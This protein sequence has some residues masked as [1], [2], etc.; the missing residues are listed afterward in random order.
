MAPI[1]T[2][3]FLIGISSLGL[4]IFALWLQHFQDIQPCPM[5][6]IQRYIFILICFFALALTVHNPKK[7]GRIT[8]LSLLAI[9]SLVGGGVSGRHLYLELNPHSSFDC[10]PDLGYMLETFTIN[11]L[12]PIIFKGTGDCSEIPW[13]FLG[14]SMAGWALVW[15]GIYLC[16]SVYLL[17]FTTKN[18]TTHHQF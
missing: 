7:I 9:A 4:I 5:C 15:F 11:Q 3:F 6:I 16:L 8:Y 18:V 1:R 14:L 13:T 2:I 10:G 12:F 17:Y